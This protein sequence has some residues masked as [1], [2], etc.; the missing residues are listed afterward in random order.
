MR[1]ITA[2]IPFMMVFVFLACN[3]D[4]ELSDLQD[5]VNELETKLDSN[6]VAQYKDSLNYL[7]SLSELEYQKYVDSISRVDSLNLAAGTLPFVYNI[8]V[9]DGS[10]TSVFSDDTYATRTTAFDGEVEVSVSQFGETRTITTTD[11]LASFDNIGRGLIKVA[12]TATDY[13]TLKYSFETLLDP[14]DLD[15]VIDASSYVGCGCEDF[16]NF[17][18]TGNIGH[19]VALFATTGSLAS[20]LT[21]RAFVE[22]DLTNS[23][24]ELVPEG[25]VITA[26]I[27]VENGTFQEEFILFRNKALF[28]DNIL[29]FGYDPIF[30]ATVDAS[31]DFTFTLAGSANE[32]GLPYHFEYS[33][34]IADQT[35]FDNTVGEIT[36]VTGQTVF[37]PD[38]TYSPVPTVINAATVS[39][40]AGS[41]ATASLDTKGDG[42]LIDIDLEHV[43]QDFQGTP[44]VII[45][46]PAAGGT[47]AAATAT[48][49][50]GR[51]T[52]ISIDN[53]GL[54][55]ALAPTVT[56][57]EGTG[58]AAT[59]TSLATNSSNGGVQSVSV[60]NS[61]NGFVSA[62][63]VVFVA[64]GNALDSTNVANFLASLA[65]APTA[66][67]NL[68]TNGTVESV[69]VDNTGSDIGSTP[70]VFITSGFGAV[71]QVTAVG[72]GGDITGITVIANGE[73]YTDDPTPVA[74]GGVTGVD[75]E[76][77]VT[78]TG[79]QVTAIAAT[80]AGTGYAVGDQFN[81]IGVG[82]GATATANYQ[83]AS[84]EDYQIT[85][86]G[87]QQ[88]DGLY[89]T[90]MPAVV[91]SAPEYQG[92]GSATATGTAVLDSE[93]RVIGITITDVGS[94][95]LA[96][97]T[98]TFISGSGVLTDAT[99]EPTVITEV[100]VD[101][102]GSGYLAPPRVEIYDANGVGSGATAVANISSD[103]RVTSIELTNA[104]TNYS[105][106]AVV[107]VDPGNAYDPSDGSIHADTAAAELTI[108]DGA[109]TAV[110]MTAFGSNYNAANVVIN[111]LRGSGF[112][113]TA[114][115][116][117]GQIT[118][119]DFT[120]GG[121]DY[122]S[123]N[124]PGA[125]MNFSGVDDFY[126]K[127]SITRVRDINYGTGARREP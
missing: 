102:P 89:Y 32:M 65:D 86:A 109:I 47:Q 45:G 114:I 19:D 73:F 115:V 9:Y 46:P 26:A 123:G 59:V 52:D 116:A 44:R 20:T 51:V 67:A 54:G 22:T 43:G 14:H 83:G 125:T 36:S 110:T 84:V 101:T 60:V 53:V 68:N 81:L 34:F 25:T 40:E 5:Q 11:G 58:A 57:T 3:K 61:G 24:K 71:A 4:D 23:T 12:V 74:A 76:F 88:S 100:D 15:S 127:T 63:N 72:G 21:G 66:T 6:L 94:G 48:V 62:P 103:G 82:S 107:I 99:I 2:L 91:F 97:P 35:V 42:A 95:Y 56:V 117:G 122:V 90:N 10:T 78:V 70:D 17:V 105:S 112:V 49:T 13:T 85:N 8:V 37:G 96:V 119:V 7:L 79:G 104:G 126:A 80:A 108:V 18:K 69:T 75:A 30:S 27:D 124:T 55:Y 50:N 92:P 87:T 93:G 77:D 16:W 111:A 121:Q 33:D 28:T 118:G 39:F 64:S 29:S 41:G 31:G 106:P 1:R 98:I 113:G 120:D 38:H